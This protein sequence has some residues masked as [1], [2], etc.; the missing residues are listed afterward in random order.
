MDIAFFMGWIFG[1]ICGIGFSIFLCKMV[2]KS[3]LKVL[4]K[5]KKITHEDDD[6]WKGEDPN[7]WKK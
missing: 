2:E 3:I 4:P 6:W 1:F 7:W 5:K